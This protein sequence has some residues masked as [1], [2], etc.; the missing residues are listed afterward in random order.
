MKTTMLRLEVL[1]SWAMRP[2]L[3]LFSTAAL[4]LCQ[5]PNAACGPVMTD[6]G[7]V[8]G[9]PAGSGCAFKGIPYAQPPTGALRFRPPVPHD[10][11]S[12]VLATTAEL[13]FC[14]Y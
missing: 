1:A 10:P 3:L 4:T 9:S 13:L 7:A 6:K 8:S 2:P 12:R 5:G 11:W 14:G